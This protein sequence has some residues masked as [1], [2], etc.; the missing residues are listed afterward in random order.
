[1]TGM[2]SKI[3]GYFILGLLPLGGVFQSSSPSPQKV[4][5]LARAVEPKVLAWF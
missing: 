5:E 4:E 3:A 1:M 2:S